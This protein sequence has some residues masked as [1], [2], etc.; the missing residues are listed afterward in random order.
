MTRVSGRHQE[1]ECPAC[2]VGEKE[3]KGTNTHGG[4]LGISSGCVSC[5]ADGEV[6]QG[7]QTEY[8]C[9]GGVEPV[10]VGG[11]IVPHAVKPGD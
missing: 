3:R 4:Y 8:V 10:V 1:R 6:E 9:E 2:D 11:I 7:E 5:F